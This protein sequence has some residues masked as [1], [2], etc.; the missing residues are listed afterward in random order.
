MT[1]TTTRRLAST[2]LAVTCLV[3]VAML[4]VEVLRWIRA[5]VFLDNTEIYIAFGIRSLARDGVLYRDLSTL[6]LV[7]QMYQPLAYLPS[8][9][10]LHVAWIADLGLLTAARLWNLPILLATLALLHRIVRHLT[11]SRDG[12]NLAVIVAVALHSVFFPEIIRLR[13][14]NGGV[15]FTLLGLLLALERPRHWWA[16]AAIA[17][18]VA[19]FF[20]PTFV[21]LPAAIFLHLVAQGDH[22]PAVRFASACAGVFAVLA[23]AAMLAFGPEYVR[24]TMRLSAANPDLPL[25]KAPVLLLMWIRL[26][27]PA[28]LPIAAGVAVLTR[29][30][31]VRSLPAIYLAA[32]IATATFGLT[33]TGADIHYLIETSFAFLIAFAA[34]LPRPRGIPV[35]I[36]ACALA[37]AWPMLRTGRNVWDICAHRHDSRIGCDYTSPLPPVPALARETASQGTE[38]IVLDEVLAFETDKILALD[39]TLLDLLVR[40]G[41]LSAA[42]LF[43]LI[44]S[45]ARTAIVF[46]R[47]SNALLE[48][49][50]EAA[51]RS[52]YRPTPDGGDRVLRRNRT[53]ALPRG[54]RP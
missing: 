9:A 50:Y 38:V 15:L 26:F 2:L 31:G 32:S 47:L 42:P 12:A 30:D 37:V 21:A 11:T 46:P 45:P 13:P 34:A 5:A 4:S 54:A 23:G 33:K 28:L 39:W 20:K 16:W 40:S 53:P 35:L 44:D 48:D 29:R 6:P 1:D 14:D 19:N 3:L 25:W 41:K 7:V 52:G 10:L 24:Q 43:A 27:G 18:A 22:R 49:L 51:L 17:I 36:A 8:A